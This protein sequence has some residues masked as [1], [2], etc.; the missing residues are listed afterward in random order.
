MNERET[1]NVQSELTTAEKAIAD[2]TYRNL[3][4]LFDNVGLEITMRDATCLRE[5]IKDVILANKLTRTQQGGECQDVLAEPLARWLWEIY[6][7]DRGHLKMF[8]IKPSNPECDWKALDDYL[9]M[10]RREQ[11]KI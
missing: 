2:N 9:K 1:L 6:G 11:E 4:R 3:K 7:L 8:E 10:L 5:K